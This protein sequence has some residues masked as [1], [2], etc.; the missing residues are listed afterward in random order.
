MLRVLLSTLFIIFKNYLPFI[1]LMMGSFFTLSF[2]C[3]LVLG[4][5][6]GL[7]RKKN[8][9]VDKFL[10]ILFPRLI[11]SLPLFGFLLLP[12]TNHEFTFFNSF[13]ILLFIYIFEYLFFSHWHNIR[14]YDNLSEARNSYSHPRIYK[15]LLYFINIFLIWGLYFSFIRFARLGTVIDLSIYFN[16][17]DWNI[18]IY[19]I[20]LKYIVGWM[21][22]ILF[23]IAD[24]M[25]KLKKDNSD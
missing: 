13:K 20:F 15:S 17:L 6:S 7:F 3:V 18:F 10:D 9:T 22:V 2:I 14:D 19:F 23:F 4:Y 1:F 5:Y 16:T 25:N 24:L 21:T 12:I 8:E 11:I